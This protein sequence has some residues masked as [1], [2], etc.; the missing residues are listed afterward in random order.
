M[1]V[2][3]SQKELICNRQNIPNNLEPAEERFLFFCNFK[4]EIVHNL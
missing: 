1:Q 4:K 3:T 2:V